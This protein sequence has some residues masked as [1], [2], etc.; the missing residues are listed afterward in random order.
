MLKL[1]GK[2]KAAKYKIRKELVSIYLSL[3][4]SDMMH[5]RLLYIYYPKSLFKQPCVKLI[6][7]GRMEIE[8]LKPDIVFT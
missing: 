2:K 7:E 3:S 4:D 5:D 1:N 6:T 8:I